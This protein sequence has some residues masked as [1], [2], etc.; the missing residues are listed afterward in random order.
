MRNLLYIFIC[1]SIVSCSLDETTLYSESF[2]VVYKSQDDKL[3]FRSD[4]GQVLIPTH[5]VSS[6]VGAGDRV[7]TTYSIEEESPNKDTLKVLPY[8]I[9][10][11]KALEL[12]AKSE[13]NDVGVDLWNVW[14]AQNFLTLDF[15]IRANNADKIKDHEYALV[16]RKSNDTLFIDFKHDSKGDNEGVLCRTA[17]AVKLDNTNTTESTIAVNYK[18]LLGNKQTIYRAIK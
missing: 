4:E 9:T 17:I 18:D 13:I 11:I 2:G 7:W 12:R 10:Q 15:R 16:S 14:I 8:R 3:Y 1:L 5:D 6:F